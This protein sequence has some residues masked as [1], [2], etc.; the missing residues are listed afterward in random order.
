MCLPVMIASVMIAYSSKLQVNKNARYSSGVGVVDIII[1][2]STG[3]GR[4][5]STSTKREIEG[6]KTI[7]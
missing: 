2:T 4:A 1:F 7:E 5:M 3:L 6:T